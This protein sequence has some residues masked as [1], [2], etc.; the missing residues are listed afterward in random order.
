MNRKN[1]SDRDLY[2][3]FVNRFGDPQK[4][5]LVVN[6]RWKFTVTRHNGDVEEHCVNNT[7]TSSG[8][9]ELAKMGISNGV[10]S[11]FLYLAIGTQT[12]ASSLDSVGGGM[13]E[14]SRK[15]ASLAANSLETMISVMTW[16]G[17]ADSLT[18]LDLRTASMVNH[19]SS[20]SG[21]HLNFVNSVAT[22]LAD[23]DFLK[24]QSEIRVGSH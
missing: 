15:T 13:G 20:G 23:S 3:E 10:G 9:N 24:V 19:A 5:N 14:V 7:L 11:A 1:M 4:D 21:I 6:G 2:N 16:G 12:A 18:S 22:I 8:L 17:A